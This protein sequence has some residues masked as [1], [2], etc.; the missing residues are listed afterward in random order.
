MG[1]ALL[2]TLGGGSVRVRLYEVQSPPGSSGPGRAIN[3]PG[4]SRPGGLVRDRGQPCH[5]RANH[6][7]FRRSER[8]NRIPDAVGMSLAGYRTY[9][10][11]CKITNSPEIPLQVA[12]QLQIS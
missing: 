10:V 7:Y 12:A 11:Y 6:P 5:T 4:D 9:Y 8:G 3:L 1:N 2:V